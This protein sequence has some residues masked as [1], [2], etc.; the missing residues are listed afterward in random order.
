MSDLNC[1]IILSSNNVLIPYSSLALCC[2][3]A[4]LTQFWRLHM[5]FNFFS[6]LGKL[7]SSTWFTG[8]VFW[9]NVSAMLMAVFCR[10]LRSHYSRNLRMILKMPRKVRH[11]I[12]LHLY[13][14]PV[15]LEDKDK[16]E[17]LSMYFL[18]IRACWWKCV[19]TR[20]GIRAKSLQWR[21]INRVCVGK[22]SLITYPDPPPKTDGKILCPCCS[23]HAH[24]VDLTLETSSI[25]Y[26]ECVS[27]KGV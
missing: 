15:E 3:H 22:W 16:E 6:F 8:S 20:S 13:L 2:K 9:V 17:L 11:G 19:S 24:F 1:E 4:I 18:Q 23:I 10:R 27:L 21:Q 26:I 14:T 5:D 7:L 25:Q 12:T